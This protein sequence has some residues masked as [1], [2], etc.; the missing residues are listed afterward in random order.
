MNYDETLKQLQTLLGIPLNQEDE[1]FMR[2]VPL[3]FTYAE[4]RIYRELTFLATTTNTNG[5]LPINARELPLPANVLVLRSLVVLHV[6]PY[7]GT[8]GVP[9]PVMQRKTLEYLTPEAFDLFWPQ[10]SFQRG[11]PERYTMIGVTTT[12]GPS[13]YQ[14]FTLKLNPEPDLAYGVEYLGVIK[15]PL[16]SANNPETILSRDYPDLF[17]AACMVFGTGYQRDFGAQADDPARAMSWEGTYK[18]LREGVMLEAARQRGESI[19]WTALPPAPAANQ[20]R[21]GM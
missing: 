11:V 10:Q 16:L 13:Q 6:V 18:T 17:C 12:V 8:S 7:Y 19:G 14:T 2:L 5:V 9:L 1:N 4:N 15:P 21:A 3:M 20:S